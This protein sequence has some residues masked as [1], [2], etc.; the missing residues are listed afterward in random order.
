MK[1]V[2]VYISYR[3]AE[4]GDSEN[5]VVFFYLSLYKLSTSYEPLSLLVSVA[6]RQEVYLFSFK[7]LLVLCRRAVSPEVLLGFFQ[8]TLGF[9]C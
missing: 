4:G 2:L 6:A 7:E 8:S 3:W 1:H 9:Y 5:R